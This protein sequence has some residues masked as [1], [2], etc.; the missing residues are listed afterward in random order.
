M[1]VCERGAG[2]GKGTSKAPRRH[3]PSHTRPQPRRPHAA[4]WHA[5]PCLVTGAHR[6]RRG[7]RDAAWGAR[8]GSV[9]A[10][11]SQQKLRLQKR[12]LGCILPRQ[13]KLC[14]LV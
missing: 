9:A 8:W 12:T 6:R 13:G 14:Q 1:Y 2:A 7:V 10:K 4:H 3:T 5:L 11:A